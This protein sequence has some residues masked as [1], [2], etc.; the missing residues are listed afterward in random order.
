MF[1]GP[2]QFLTLLAVAAAFFFAVT[3]L[4][5]RTLAALFGIGFL[6]LVFLWLSYAGSQVQ[7]VDA[8]GE[9]AAITSTR[10]QTTPSLSS[11]QIS[12]EAM[13][14]HLTRPRIVLDSDKLDS[15][16][17]KEK[18][19]D[20]IEQIEVAKTEVEKTEVAKTK[21]TRPS[22]V[23][24]P[25]KRV[26][27]VYREVVSVGP[28]ETESECYHALE[29]L[30]SN[31]VK[32]RIEQLVPNSQVP[33]LGQ[34]GMGM[35]YVLR[36]LCNDA[37]TEVIYASFGEMKHVHVQMQFGPAQDQQLQTAF[38]NYQRQGRIAKVGG[39]AGLGIGGLALLFGLL[40][41]DTWTRGDYTKRLFFGV[42][43]AIIGLLLLFIA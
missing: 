19:T 29:P 6:M 42:P 2:L 38:R 43:A 33:D 3:K 37:W 23:D 10:A 12:T 24:N 15:D 30:L 28:Y 13:W 18:T 5:A 26:G 21:P 9:G 36:D 40:K 17:A 39:I 41:A 22:W 31:V 1:A 20:E 8:H 11:A 7:V 35:E 14:E 32:Q 4:N 16:Q 25:P 27:N 34:L